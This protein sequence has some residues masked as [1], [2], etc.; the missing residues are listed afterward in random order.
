MS[1]SFARKVKRN[2]LRALLLAEARAHGC[3]CSPDIT[4]PKIEAGKVRMAVIAH[5][6]DCP[7]RKAPDSAYDLAA[8][9][10]AGE[11]DKNR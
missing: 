10:N 5:D 9:I 11:W 1:N 8:R 3:T 4:L 6:N 2:Q 7:H